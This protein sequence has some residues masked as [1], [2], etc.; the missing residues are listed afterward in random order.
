MT[1][2][3]V[4]G[5]MCSY[6]PCRLLEK[7]GYSTVYLGDVE[8]KTEE[9]TSS[10]PRN[11]CSYMLHCADLLIRSKIDGLILTNCCNSTQRLYDYV[12]QHR[13]D[14]FCCMLE[15]PRNN[16]DSAC[17]YFGAQV[18]Q[19]IEKMQ[20]HFYPRLTPQFWH[21]PPA[22]RNQKKQSEIYI[23]ASAVSPELHRFLQQV[24]SNYTVTI[25]HCG[26]RASGDLLW[27][28]YQHLQGIIQTPP[29]DTIPCTRMSQFADQF[30][31]YVQ[32]GNLKAVVYLS[33]KNCDHFLMQFPTVQTICQAA[34]IPVIEL[35]TEFAGAGSGQLATR[36]EAFTECLQ[37]QGKLTNAEQPA[38]SG[39]NPFVQRMK[40]VQAVS[41]NA[42]LRAIRMVVENQIDI[43]TNTIWKHPEK[44]IWTN[45]V[46]PQELFYAAGL[47]PVNMELAAGWLASLRLSHK[48]IA[49]CE[50][51]WCSPSVCSYHKATLGLLQSGGLSRP[52]AAAISSHICDGSIGTVNDWK[53]HY[54]TNT[55]ILDVPFQQAPDGTAYL[56]RQFKKLIAWI[57]TY[58]GQALSEEKIRE[59]L[60]LS[61]QARD[62]WL[63]VQ[64]LRKGDPAVPG[65]YMLRN[66][67]GAT[68]L[69]GS[70]FGL[71]V[72]RTYHAEMQQ[73]YTAPQNQASPAKRK[74]ILWIHFAP[75][76]HNALLEY[77]E[78]TLACTIVYDITGYIYW[79]QYDLDMPLESLAQRAA[80]HFYL[81]EPEK[82]QKLYA[83]IIR[84]YRIDGVIHMMHN[85]C[86]AIPGASWQVRDTADMLGIPYLELSGDCI[87]P[88]G[89]S[90]AQMKLRLEAFGEMLWR[91]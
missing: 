73:K 82:R 56:T 20:K 39:D 8:S 72:M 26:E 91:K 45:M 70:R 58:T 46:M 76:Y 65:R 10:L 32:T 85:G 40:L 28:K 48:Y 30:T 60:V 89:F 34:G 79:Q 42:P 17:R 59:A 61:N 21:N 19:L 41:S 83:D 78:E 35:E 36:L 44:I 14:I 6:V 71:D 16:T 87:D 66:L 67:F 37:N 23:F 33:A 77:L 63:K 12:K 3:P 2:K 15:L 81:G 13:P 38:C 1:H 69:F 64:T 7:L 29:D 25:D 24:F 74:R 57:E 90:A 86:R 27:L 50:G 62:Y 88:R 47:V 4:I 9:N 43:F 75:L 51:T 49:Y 54:G 68:F 18:T 55:F 5:Y 52:R 31:S 53:Q 11:L 22:M 80:S 84:E